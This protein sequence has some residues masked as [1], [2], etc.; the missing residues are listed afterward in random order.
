MSFEALPLVIGWELTL[1]CNLRC[2]HCGSSAGSPRSNELTT[3]EALALCD[4]LPDLLVQ[5]VDFSGGEPLLRPDWKEIAF[6]LKDLKIHTNILTHGLDLT[7]EK[8]KE[9]SEAGITCVG[10]SIDGLQK[11]HDFIRGRPGGFQR[12]LQ[13]IDLLNTLGMKSNIITT[14]SSLNV[15][16][17]P[18][19]MHTLQQHHVTF[20][21]LQPL[22]PIGRVKTS[23]LRVENESILKLGRFI[24]QHKSE[25]MEHGLEIIGA[26]GLQYIFEEE[27][28]QTSKPWRGCPA[29]W[30]T[31]SITSDGKVKGCLAMPD[32]LIEGDLRNTELWDIWFSPNAFTYNRKFS[33]D[34]LG[35]N[36]RECDMCESCK[37]GCS[38]NSYSTTG[39]FH[40]DPYC[41][42]M[43]NKKLKPPDFPAL[44]PSLPRQPL[45]L[46]S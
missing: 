24:Q 9:I 8:I 23:Q 31:C 32:E 45:A 37:G 46:T 3:K 15:D 14:V 17:L 20:W 33:P 2:R 7:V 29:G 10:L 21:R 18:E 26:D 25:A 6:R 30:S 28:T 43:V 13:S 42:Y 35:P 44:L 11:N 41:F 22:M 38:T 27:K 1:S 34:Q 4:Q 39:I 19:L 12:T 36:C 5:E 16:D 40:N